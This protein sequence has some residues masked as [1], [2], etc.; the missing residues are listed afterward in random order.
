MKAAMLHVS[1][2]SRKKWRFQQ[3]G[4]IKTVGFLSKVV[5]N[6][7]SSMRAVAR[8]ILVIEALTNV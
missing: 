6:P 1:N 3:Y 2:V 7:K 8:V 4:F 5:E